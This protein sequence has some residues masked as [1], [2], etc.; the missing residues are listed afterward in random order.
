MSRSAAHDAR[1]TSLQ[2]LF[3]NPF[4][5]KAAIPPTAQV[6]PEEAQKL[7]LEHYVEDIPS[8]RG[9]RIHWLGDRSAKKVLLY[10]HGDALTAQRGYFQLT[11]PQVVA[12]ASLL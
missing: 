8:S 10:F 7:N 6:I 9:A 12:F 5:L 1:N 4:E 3:L 11:S 2:E